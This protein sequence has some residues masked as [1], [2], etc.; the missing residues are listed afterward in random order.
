VYGGT[1]IL[2]SL[3]SCET[4]KQGRRE[5]SSGRATEVFVRRG[6]RWVNTGWHLD[7]GS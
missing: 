7:S 2:Y 6:G 3:Y 5:T 4:E 1:A